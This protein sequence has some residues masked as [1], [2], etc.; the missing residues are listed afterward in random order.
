MISTY[1][2]NVFLELCVL[3]M[4]DFAI[5]VFFFFCIVIN[6]ESF[7]PIPKVA[8]QDCLVCK[9]VKKLESTKA[10]QIIEKH[11]YELIDK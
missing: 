4:W 7:P 10:K 5:D 3:W 1:T 11:L 6:Y 9:T 8:I 2:D